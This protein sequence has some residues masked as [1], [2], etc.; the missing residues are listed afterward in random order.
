VDARS[1]RRRSPIATVNGVLRTGPG[2]REVQRNE[3]KQRLQAAALARFHDDGF[4]ATSVAAIAADAG[5]TERTFFRYF[6]SKEAVLF[7]DY[8]SR[9]EWF[10]AAL[11]VR[12]A[13][14]PVLES[15]K[16]ATG[17]FPDDRE[18]LHQ[19]AALRHGLLSAETIES[20]LRL[21]QGAFSRELEALVKERLERRREVDPPGHDDDQIEFLAVV[22]GNAI[23]GAML[24]SLDI[25]TRRGGGD[26]DDM[27][28]LQ[29]E[30]FELLRNFPLD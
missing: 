13:D 18:I 11:A 12:P 1:V 7:Q 20:H 27:T 15:V 14:E 22:L 4:D 8:E 29:A 2:K 26:P 9:L 30:A 17:S 25:W 28:A 6:P 24:G 3:T 19:V 5:V 10:R 23:A 21:V 16:V